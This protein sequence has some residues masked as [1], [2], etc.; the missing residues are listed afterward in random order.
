[1]K[2]SR[3]CRTKQWLYKKKP[4]KT[5][6]QRPSLSLVLLSLER[7]SFRETYRT[8]SSRIV[9]RRL[10]S[11]IITGQMSAEIK[12]KKRLLRAWKVTLETKI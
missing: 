3:C 9:L 11:R 6:S 7:L 4:R 5:C 12:I 1:M 2:A 8:T 10:R